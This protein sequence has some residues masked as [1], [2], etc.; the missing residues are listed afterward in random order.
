MEPKH[1]ATS[2]IK[3]LQGLTD[4][5][6][7]LVLREK[8]RSGLPLGY[9]LIRFG[10][11]NAEQWYD[12]VL[13]EFKPPVINLDSITIEKEVIFSLPEFT[14][15][16][17]QV[18]PVFKS[19]KKIVCAMVDPLDA[20]SLAELSK[21]S[22]LEIEARL[23]K[24]TDLRKNFDKY[25]SQVGFVVINPVSSKEISSDEKFFGPI[26]L[27]DVE[28]ETTAESAVLSMISQAVDLKAT[29]IHIEVEEG[30]LRLRYRINGLLYEFPPPPLELYSSIVSHI[31]VLA[32]L[33]IAEKRVP[34]DGYFK[35]RVG[36]RGVDLR[37]STFPIIFGEMVALRV[38][39]KTNIVTGLEQLGFLPE[40]LHRWRMLLDEPYGMLLVTGPTGSG[41][42]TTLYSSLTELDSLHRKIMT[43]EDPVEYHLKGVDQVHINP[44][45][46]LTFAI[47]LRSILRQDPNIVM[48]GEIRDIESASSAFRAAQTGQLVLSTLHTN[49]APGAIIR[50]LDMGVES[51][52]IASSLIG[53]LSQ[54]L[55]RSLCS[56][57]KESY[58]PL[59]E[60]I[61]ELGLQSSSNKMQFYRGKGCH[62]CKGTGYAGRTGLFE[63]MVMNEE[64][65]HVTMKDPSSSQLKDLSV[66]FGMKTLRQDGI[67]KVLQGI[68]TISEVLYATKKETDER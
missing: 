15:R 24:E 9:L 67:Q 65:R 53:V 62:I 50:L 46:G 4:E 12:F 33:D 18:L 20:E 68:T 8:Q 48:V 35:A 2:K 58:K 14:C 60:E 25:F 23:V 41:K 43:V 30:G 34:Q 55:I 40:I 66:K 54:R 37:V 59:E 29:D 21:I 31:K 1:P 19:S 26:R 16:K 5:Q 42:T 36:G 56:N 39:D 44:K 45:S 57:C 28:K 13:R 61:K 63:L 17:Y 27:K 52:L 6:L 49:T 7:D 51:Y 3:E 38:L 64:L 10:L 32:N 47:S 11:F 22:G